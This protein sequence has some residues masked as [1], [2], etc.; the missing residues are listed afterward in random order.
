MNEHCYK[1]GCAEDVN[2]ADLL[3]GYYHG[4]HPDGY[5]ALWRTTG[6]HE[7][8]HALTVVE[9]DKKGRFLRVARALPVTGW[10]VYEPRGCSK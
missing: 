2:L 8:N 7:H 6:R 1:K 4:I 9:V 10:K 5:K 3:I